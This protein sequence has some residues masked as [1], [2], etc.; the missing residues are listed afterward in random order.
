[1][2]SVVLFIGCSFCIS[3]AAYLAVQIIWGSTATANAPEI[4]NVS[5]PVIQRDVRAGGIIRLDDIEWVLQK[6]VGAEPGLLTRQS[7]EASSMKAIGISK[8][9]QKGEIVLAEH[10]LWPEDPGFIAQILRPDYQAV[11]VHFSQEESSNLSFGL[12]T[13]VDI[14]LT[15]LDVLPTDTGKDLELPLKLAESLRVLVVQNKINSEPYLLVEGTDVQVK[16]VLKGGTVGSLKVVMTA[17][18]A[19]ETN[20]KLSDQALI[21][22]QGLDMGDDRKPMVAQT[23]EIIIQR[24]EDRDVMLFSSKSGGAHQ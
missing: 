4:P 1:M 8:D 23:P 9:Y 20:E 5:Y 11:A 2:R 3:L 21:R 6:S 14:Y 10:V 16:S 13:L 22:L 15:N 7:L 17:K 18:F 24:G 12:G 19:Q